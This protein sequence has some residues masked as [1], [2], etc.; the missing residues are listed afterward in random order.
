MECNHTQS[1]IDGYFHSGSILRLHHPW[2]L[3]CHS[4]LRYLLL[5]LSP[6]TFAKDVM[7]FSPPW[8][9]LYEEIAC[10][11]H[12]TLPYWP[13][14][15]WSLTRWLSRAGSLWLS[16]GRYQEH[17]RGLHAP[18]LESFECGT[19]IYFFFA[20]SQYIL[21]INP[22]YLCLPE[23]LFSFSAN[24]KIIH[25]TVLPFISPT[26]WCLS[27]ILVVNIFS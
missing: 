1:S 24:R 16:E 4:F 14:F 3:C 15:A 22:H 10:L 9:N 11:D 5:I 19:Q 7:L 27:D 12:V 8:E 18:S 6:W 26:I 25:K 23:C 20:I 2:W 17:R 13:A 21:I